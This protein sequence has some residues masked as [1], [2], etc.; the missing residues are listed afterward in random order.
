VIYRDIAFLSI[1]CAILYKGLNYGKGFAMKNLKSELN[2]DGTKTVNFSEKV[3]KALK[4]LKHPPVD[5]K[6]LSTLNMSLVK[7]H[8]LKPKE[9]VIKMSEVK[10]TFKKKQYTEADYG[11]VK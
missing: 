10:N 7:K 3:K 8:V 2:I 5:F 11:E 6:Q 4:K 1:E 9:S